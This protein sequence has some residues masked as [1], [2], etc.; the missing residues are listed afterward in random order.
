MRDRDERKGPVRD[1]L[2]AH[3]VAQSYSS[4]SGGSFREIST[5]SKY[6]HLNVCGKF[7]T[8]RKRVEILDS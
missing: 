3:N 4:L 8:M 1:T 7:K 6:E 2:H 5:T